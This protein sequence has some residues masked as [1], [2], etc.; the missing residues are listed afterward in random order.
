MKDQCDHNNVPVEDAGSRD[1]NI[2]AAIKAMMAIEAESPTQIKTPS[3]QGR[4]KQ[5]SKKRR[6][7]VS[8]KLP[9][10]KPT[11]RQA[12]L[13]A[14]FLVMVVKPWLLPIL[15]VLVLAILL[16]SYWTLGHDRSVEVGVRAMEVFR[17]YCPE[18][19]A[20]LEERARN[21]LRRVNAMVEKL[22]EKWKE[23]LYLPDLEPASDK[24]E[25][26]QND[27]FDR[28]TAD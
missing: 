13:A 14:G 17:K 11:V 23:G 9:R 8:L 10:Y 25:K 6:L 15:L 24:P 7:N 28:L 1:E 12:A 3:Q 16:V 20:R 27:P 26:M 5:R 4:S 21:G 18:L 19:A 22:P 2:D